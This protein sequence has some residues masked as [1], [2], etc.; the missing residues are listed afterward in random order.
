[1]KNKSLLFLIFISIAVGILIS[2][3][4]AQSGE[5]TWMHGDNFP[6]AP[7]VFGTQG[8]ADP[9]NKPPGL[10]ETS[11][12]KDNNGNFWLFGGY[13]SNGAN[14]GALELRSGN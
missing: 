13:D 7:G 9:A 11:E 3:S 1:M 14:Y 10:Y 2:K 5:W 12:W 4:Y 8:V 6:N